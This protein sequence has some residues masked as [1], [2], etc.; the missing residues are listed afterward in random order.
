MYADIGP[1]SRRS[2]PPISTHSLDD[3]RVEYAQLNYQNGAKKEKAMDV[4]VCSV[5]K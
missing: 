5:G 3:N 4:T 2:R 1:S